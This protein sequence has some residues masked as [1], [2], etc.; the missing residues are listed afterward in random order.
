M[1]KTDQTYNICKKI[2]KEN[3]P[4]SK[5]LNENLLSKKY[6]ISRASLR[7]SLKILKSKGIIK[8]K[9]KS[10][11]FMEDRENLNYFD[12]DILNW[13]KGTIFENNL[14]KYLV[15]TRL[16]IEPEIAYYCAQRIDKKNKNELQL[17][18]NKMEKAIL[19]KDSKKIVE[20]DL[21]FHKKILT[22]SKNPVL[23][24][25]FD[26]INH[27]LEFNFN[28]NKDELKNYFVNWKNKYLPQHLLLKNMILKNQPLKARNQMIKII[29]EQKKRFL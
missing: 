16:M 21:A 13:S 7:E 2:F 4:G 23:Y 12:K 20:N 15:E 25:L 3:K 14:R 5:L 8:S 6:G 27:I 18:Y 26:L 17:I 9:Q 11:T 22:S 28:A 19:D 29:N 10:G 1:K 24:T